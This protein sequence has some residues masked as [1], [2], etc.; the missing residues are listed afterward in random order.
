MDFDLAPPDQPPPKPLPLIGDLPVSL[1]L[2]I[3]AAAFLFFLIAGT[4][5]ALMD[6]RAAQQGNAQL[7]ASGELKSLAQRLGRA[8]QGAQLGEAAAYA[9]L[10]NG[11]ERFNLVLDAVDNGGTLGSYAMPAASPALRPLLDEVR[12]RWE[13]GDKGLPLIAGAAKPMA[14]LGSMVADLDAKLPR[15]ADLAGQAGG[16]L[17]LLVERIGRNANLFRDVSAVDEAAAVQL[18]KDLAAAIE[19]SGAKQAELTTML[20]SWQ[21]ALPPEAELKPLLQAK[22]AAG[23]MAR[24]APL[25]DAADKLYAA[26]A[27]SI[28]ARGDH[29]ALVATFGS[30]TLA[31]LVLMLKA[32][33]DDARLRRAEAEQQ[34]AAAEQANAATQAAV[35]RLADE[36]EDVAD[37][38]LT[39]R[40][41][42][43]EDLTG[44]IAEAMNYAI[45]ELAVLV[46]RINGAAEQMANAAKATALTSDE[47]LAATDTQSDQIRSASGEVLSMA[48]SMHQASAYA[49][50]LA[51]VARQ[52]LEAAGNG[53]AAVRDAIAGMNDIRAQIQDTSK[54]IKRLGESS[55]EIGEIVELISDITEQT[56]VL[57]LNAAIQAASAGEAGRGF[58][59]VAEEVQRLAERSAEATK[60]IAALV[61]TI[62]SDTHEAVAAMERSTQN[63]VEGAR[64]S[65]ATGQ[66]LGEISGVS[67]N[68]AQRVEGLSADTQRQAEVATKVAEAMKD[69]LKITARTTE[70]T[71]DTAIAIGELADLAVELRGSVSRFRV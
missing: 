19:Q 25:R 40:A 34:R 3:L 37:G 4:F 49:R 8:A 47:L 18:T 51:Q 20:K 28:A 59:V 11:R 32:I 48:Q 68:L 33:M 39:V 27:E 36:L 44:P 26:I 15:A 69:I 56:N 13:S 65:D 60:Q 35:E 30:M 66:A 42:V 70:G 7:A 5:V 64:L 55:Q 14:A 12:R 2:Q 50:D 29:L 53:S 10:S 54:R 52:A 6:S 24:N 58:S 9:E 46:A 1:Q 31:T 67:Q 21:A 71:Q 23:N 41:S 61:R 16:S 22:Q 38:N 63:V 43:E 57:A 62:Q 45:G 17:P